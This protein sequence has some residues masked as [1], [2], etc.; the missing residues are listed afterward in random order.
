[1]IDVMKF[2]ERVCNVKLGRTD[3]IARL[4]VATETSVTGFNLLTL[5]KTFRIPTVPNPRGLCPFSVS[6][7]CVASFP[8][9]CV[10]K[11]GFHV[12]DAETLMAEILPPFD[13]HESALVAVALSSDGK[14][15]AAAAEKTGHVRVFDIE[16][17]EKTL[18]FHRDGEVSSLAFSDNGKYLAVATTRGEC[19]V[20]AT[21]DKE[22]MPGNPKQSGFKGMFFS[23]VYRMATITIPKVKKAV[24]KFIS[25]SSTVVVVTEDSTVTE[26]EVVEAGPT[27]GY[28][29]KH[30]PS[31]LLSD[32]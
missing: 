7:S 2:K 17:E 6:K 10:G 22:A 23:P 26:A 31:K 21:D 15:V 1:M 24:V 11:L 5:T 30:E 8:A 12:E 13:V 32:E 19:Q 16:S 4:V 27:L 18:E 9:E 29:I 14:L 3:S 25:N 28:E 20:Y